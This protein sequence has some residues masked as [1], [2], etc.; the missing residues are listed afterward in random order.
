MNS[1]TNQTQTSNRSNSTTTAVTFKSTTRLMINQ[2][3]RRTTFSKDATIRS[4][5]DTT[6]A[7][8][9]TTKRSTYSSDAFVVLNATTVLPT[10]AGVLTTGTIG[11]TEKQKANQVKFGIIVGV[12]FTTFLLGVISYVTFIQCQKFRKILIER[13]K[14]E[15]DD[16]RPVLTRR[17]S[18]VGQG[19]KQVVIERRASLIPS[20]G[21]RKQTPPENF[22]PLDSLGNQIPASSTAPLWDILPT[23]PNNQISAF[24]PYL[25][26]P[27]FCMQNAIIK[28]N[29]KTY[30]E[31]D[32][33]DSA[34][35]NDG[36]E[37]TSS[38]TQNKSLL[39][40]VHS[41]DDC[42]GDD[43]DD[44]AFGSYRESQKAL[45]T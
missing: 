17:T 20:Q 23:Y 1:S 19:Q 44:M 5:V 36:E 28:Y 24:S 25:Y 30:D 41:G 18:M 7:S 2:S 42:D 12:C 31:D 32:D 3:K 26:P 15:E 27:G 43:D 8:S 29:S 11:L 6:T 38:T 13:R 16:E 9:E 37:G 10:V 21:G 33:A 45:L 22:Q 39:S 14:S 4:L 34:V 40:P 35:S